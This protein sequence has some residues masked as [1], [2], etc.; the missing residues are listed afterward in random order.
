MIEMQTAIPF[1]DTYPILADKKKPEI[2]FYYTLAADRVKPELMPRDLCYLLPA[3]SWSRVKMRP[4]G[5]EGFRLAA[6]CGG[7]VATKKW[8][9]YRYTPAQYVDWLFTFNPEWAA[10]MDYCCEDEITEG[11]PGVVRF[12]Q[13]RTTAMAYRF[14]DQY[15]FAP[16]AWVPTIQGWNVEDY[17][18]HAAEMRPL[19]LEMQAFY[20]AMGNP[21]FRVG[22][23][24]L[25]A[26]AKNDMIFKVVHAVRDVLKG[27]KFH[28]WGVKLR[29]L[30]TSTLL[31][32]VMS[33][34]SAAW[35]YTTMASRHR[36][37]EHQ[38]SLGMKQ[39]E[40]DHKIMLPDYRAKVEKA[41]DQTRQLYL[42]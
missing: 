32:D 11:K 35:A 20:E 17:Q 13:Q 39:R 3:S 8:G 15:R 28:L 23:G 33:V 18:E 25:C 37:I 30:Q 42:F 9:D 19:I 22:I 16:W 38:A 41:I 7:F 40:Y 36:R 10:T 5:L 1:L 29:A 12:R 31:P 6:D 14:W 34:D 27:V 2:D 21:H 26:R 4:P 24:T